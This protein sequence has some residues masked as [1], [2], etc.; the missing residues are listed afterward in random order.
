MGV[1]RP[2]L[3]DEDDVALVPDL[4]QDLF[5]V[6]GHEARGAE[7]GSTDEVEDGVRDAL[8]AHG[9]KDDDV[10]R[11]GA[12]GPRHA[13]LEDGVR[14]AEHALA[15]SRQAARR[16]LN[17][18]CASLLVRRWRLGR[19]RG[20]GQREQGEDQNAVGHATPWG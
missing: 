1:P 7:A 18:G 6:A 12:A 5:S 9:W 2:T 17:R 4:L 15:G 3:I 8:R 16:Q 14:A 11:D 20:A 19:T 13:I 10:E